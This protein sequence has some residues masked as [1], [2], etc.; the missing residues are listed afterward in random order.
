MGRL[1]GKVVLITGAG[2]G[3]GRAAA[4]R[5]VKEGAKVML[6]GRR[7]ALLSELVNDSLLHFCRSFSSE[8][9]GQYL[10]RSLTFLKNV[11]KIASYQH[12]S[13]SRASSCPDREPLV[14][15]FDCS[16]LLFGESK[17]AH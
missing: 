4:T 8:G 10:V 2:T 1:D 14:L 17:T 11:L 7:R 6:A 12:C 5:F 16:L 15:G 9:D 13:F 3:I